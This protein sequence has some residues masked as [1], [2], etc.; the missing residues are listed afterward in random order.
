MMLLCWCWVLRSD[1]EE[2]DGVEERKGEEVMEE[3]GEGEWRLVQ[4]L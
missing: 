4:S 3:D 1:E 2:G